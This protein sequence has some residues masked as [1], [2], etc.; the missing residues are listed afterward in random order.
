MEHD[1]DEDDNRTDEEIK[2]IKNAYVNSESWTIARTIYTSLTIYGKVQL[3]QEKDDSSVFTLAFTGF[4]ISKLD[5]Y[6]GDHG[7]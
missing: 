1:E 7:P 6:K 4:D 3:D 5:F 2:L